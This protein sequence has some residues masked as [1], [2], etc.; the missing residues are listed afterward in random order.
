MNATKIELYG[1]DLLV[2][3]DPQT[4]NPC[5]ALVSRSGV[6]RETG[7]AHSGQPEPIQGGDR[8]V[9]LAQSARYLAVGGKKCALVGADA[10]VWRFAKD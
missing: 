10:L 2:E 7:P 8:V 3:L 6:V 4:A 9:V 1:L 5:L